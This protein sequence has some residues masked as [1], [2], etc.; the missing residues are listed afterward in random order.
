MQYMRAFR[1]I[2]NLQ[3]LLL[4]INVCE[5]ALISNSYTT[6]PTTHNEQLK[7]KKIPFIVNSD[8]LGARLKVQC[9]FTR[10]DNQQIWLILLVVL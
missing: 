6:I 5:L 7:E 2:D 8:S 1:G 9:K 3:K 4:A 10:I